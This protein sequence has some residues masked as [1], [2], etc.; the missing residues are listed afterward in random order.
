[1]TQLAIGE[2]GRGRTSLPWLCQRLN[3]ATGPKGGRT[4]AHPQQNGL[5]ALLSARFAALNL[6]NDPLAILGHLFPT[7][8]LNK[9]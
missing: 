6:P 8:S 4:H 1:M 3:A 5:I 9:K 2:A 7:G